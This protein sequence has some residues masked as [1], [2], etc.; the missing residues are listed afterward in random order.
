MRQ[1]RVGRFGCVI[2][3]LFATCMAGLASAQP[4][5]PFDHELL[6]DAAP[7]K[8]SK[9]IPSLDIKADGAAEIVL[10]CNTVKAQLVVAGDTITVITGPSTGSQCAPERVRADED[11]MA[12]LTQATNWRREGDLLILTGGKTVRFRLQTN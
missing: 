9:R 11:L 6:L 3:A 12:A 2:A 8:G 4:S 5:F 10:W 7:M 1:R